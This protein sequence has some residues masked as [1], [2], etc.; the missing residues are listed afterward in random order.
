[1]SVYTNYISL[2]ALLNC[3]YLYIIKSAVVFMCLIL[4]D[5]GWLVV[6]GPCLA[7]LLVDGAYSVLFD[8]WG[9]P[10][11]RSVRAWGSQFTGA[12]WGEIPPSTI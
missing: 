4:V 12:P 11:A 6:I 8:L 2:G 7:T 10:D 5:D 3:H 9:V 1:M